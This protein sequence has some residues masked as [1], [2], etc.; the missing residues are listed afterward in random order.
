MYEKNIINKPDLILKYHFSTSFVQNG[1]FI[2]VITDSVLI[3]KKKIIYDNNG[4][5]TTIYKFINNPSA[6]YLT[7]DKSLI[8]D[9]RGNIIEI[10]DYTGSYTS[11][12]WSYANRLPAIII[13]NASYSTVASKLQTSFLE[14]FKWK[15]VPSLDD[16]ETILMVLNSDNDLLQSNSQITCYKYGGFGKITEVID[17]RGVRVNYEYDNFFR[18]NRISDHNDKTIESYEYKYVTGSTPIF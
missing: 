5:P 17:P 10:L 15:I 2:Q 3:D 11:I 9:S 18:L 6:N 16:Y 12:L 8:Y 14:A 1:E 4:N 7:F 13:K